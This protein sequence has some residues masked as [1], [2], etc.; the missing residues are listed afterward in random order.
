MDTIHDVGR[1]KPCPDTYTTCQASLPVDNTRFCSFC[2]WNTS[3]TIWRGGLQ[4]NFLCFI[5]EDLKNSHLGF[6][7]EDYPRICKHRYNTNT[8]KINIART[9]TSCSLPSQ[10][11]PLDHKSSRHGTEFKETT[12]KK[13]WCAVKTQTSYSVITLLPYVITSLDGAWKQR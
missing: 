13:L 9:F 3:H 6:W 8:R 7:A 10:Q 4:N 12:T 11:P 1:I 5:S 2:K